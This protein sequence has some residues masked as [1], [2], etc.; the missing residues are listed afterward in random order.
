MSDTAKSLRETQ[1]EAAL[2]KS[3]EEIAGSQ[4]LKRM[5][6]N[7]PMLRDKMTQMKLHGEM[8]KIAKGISDDEAEIDGTYAAQM[9]DPKTGDFNL[10]AYLAKRPEMIQN[11]AGTEEELPTIEEIQADPSLLK[12]LKLTAN[13]ALHT[14]E[15]R[16]AERLQK[17]KDDAQ[18]QQQGS[19]N[20]AAMA[21]LKYE[22]DQMNERSKED[23]LS[24]EKIQSGHDTAKIE[25]AE[26]K[27]KANITGKAMKI[28]DF[29]NELDQRMAAGESFDAIADRLGVNL[30]DETA[31]EYKNRIWA[32][33]KS[34]YATQAK[35]FEKGERTEHPA[36]PED[37]AMLMA[38][39][40]FVNPKGLEKGLPVLNTGNVEVE[41]PET[42]NEPKTKIE[43]INPK[44]EAG[45]TSYKDHLKAM[46]QEGRGQ[47]ANPAYGREIAAW[48]SQS[49]QIL[50]NSGFNDRQIQMMKDP[51]FIAATP[52]EQKEAL[53]HLNK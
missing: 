27:A 26:K 32:A 37:I 19:V 41:R 35:L 47:Q 48:K 50:K 23:R 36:S 24:R 13:Y 34:E 18:M 11:G 7:D 5:Y 16:A 4:S 20:A 33:A 15:S 49:D 6:D 43:K 1:R 42:T 25:A 52:E 12:K 30:D 14:K 2:L 29:G 9:I 8:T 40:A 21:R 44:Q 31:K 39:K 17:Q 38:Q 28:G 53:A 51:D 46:P 10:D 3:Q 22:Q 45:L